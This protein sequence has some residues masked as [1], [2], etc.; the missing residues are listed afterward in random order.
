MTSDFWFIRESFVGVMDESNE[1]IL[2]K[3][4]R[5]TSV[6]WNYFERVRKADACYAVCI[7]STRNSAVPATAG[8]LISG[9][10]SCVVSEEPTT[11]V[12]I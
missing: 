7:Q 2:Q 8:R 12:G 3:S 10:I 5:L 9:T 1:I 4:K 11:T 6:V